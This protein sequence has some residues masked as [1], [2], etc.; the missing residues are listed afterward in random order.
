MT[1]MKEKL[2]IQSK[3]A[4]SKRLRDYFF[5]QDFACK[6]SPSGKI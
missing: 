1:K 3:V 5:F 4:G 6:K 2:N